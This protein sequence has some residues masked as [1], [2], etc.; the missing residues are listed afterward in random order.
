MKFK[1]LLLALLVVVTLCIPIVSAYSLVGNSELA[2]NNGVSFN[3]TPATLIGSGWVNINFTSDSLNQNMNLLV[4]VNDSDMIVDGMQYYN[5]HSEIR[6]YICEGIDIWYNR[7]DSHF[8]CWENLTESNNTISVLPLYNHEYSDNNSEY[9]AFYWYEI[10]N[11]SDLVMNDNPLNEEF[12]NKNMWYYIESFPVEADAYYDIRVH[13]NIPKTRLGEVPRL[14]EYD[15]GLNPSNSHSA[16]NPYYIDPWAKGTTGL[17]AYYKMEETTGTNV[18]DSYGKYNLTSSATI[19]SQAGIINTGAN[20]SSSLTRFY[21]TT[22]NDFDTPN[23]SISTWVYPKNTW[24][25]N[26]YATDNPIYDN[27]YN[28]K[29]WWDG[30]HKQ[31]RCQVNTGSLIYAYSTSS[32][33][34][35]TWHQIV[36]TGGLN[37]PL[38]LWIDGVEQTDS[39]TAG[40]NYAGGAYDPHVGGDVGEGTMYYGVMDEFGYWNN[41]ILNITDIAYLYNSGAPSTYQQP[42][43]DTPPVFTQNLVA[44]TINHNTTLSYDVNCTSSNTLIYYVNNSMVNI[45]SGTGVITD[46]PV[47]GDTGSY[48]ISVIC[49]DGTYNTTQSFNYT[50]TDNA[51]STGT[52]VVN[53]NTPTM[54]TS[55]IS[56]DDTSTSDPD[57]DIV[58][59]TYKWFKD[60]ANTGVTTKTISNASFTLYSNFT[61]EIKPTDTVLTGT[62]HNSTPVEI[63]VGWYY[64]HNENGDNTTYEFAT[65]S[66]ILNVSN[67]VGQTLSSYSFQFIYDGSI[68]NI[69]PS[70]SGST[71]IAT[72]NKFFDIENAT[73]VANGTHSYHWIMNGITNNG[74][75]INI[76]STPHNIIVLPLFNISVFSENTTDWMETDSPLISFTLTRFNSLSGS[77]I[78]PNVLINYSGTDYALPYNTTSTN[79]NCGNPQTTCNYLIYDNQFSTNLI[80][81]DT[82]NKTLIP[83]YT[84]I[85]NG[86]SYIR[87]ADGY[88]W[89]NAVPQTSI[90]LNGTAYKMILTN[91]SNLSY[92]NITVMNFTFKDEDTLNLV[93]ASSTNNFHSYITNSN[94]SRQISI[95]ETNVSSYIIC[96]KYGLNFQNDFNTAYSVTNFTPRTYQITNE[97][98]DNSSIDYYT[99]LMLNLSSAQNIIVHVL[100]EI[101]AGY[102]STLTNPVSVEAYMYV[103]LT[104]DY[105]LVES[106]Y[107]DIA[108][109]VQFFLSV[110]K[111]HEY[112]FRVKF[113]STYVYPKIISDSSRFVMSYPYEYW[114]RLPRYGLNYLDTSTLL[115]ILQSQTSITY[116]NNTNLITGTWTNM[117][118]TLTNLCFA[119]YN[120]TNWNISDSYTTQNIVTANRIYRNCTTSTSGLVNYNLGNIT[121]EYTAVFV[122][123]LSSDNN[124][125]IINALN[126]ENYPSNTLGGLGFFL[127]FLLVGTM[128]FA[129]LELGSTATIVLCVGSL[130][131]TLFMPIAMMSKFALVGLSLV[132]LIIGLLINR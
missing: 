88:A 70:I 57:G 22:T 76:S 124:D 29:L 48:N 18:V 119:V 95:S 120:T 49:G 112:M 62:A 75:N 21:K 28:A 30:S 34:K 93:N 74:S 25:Y 52:P 2:T 110:D 1:F 67:D 26:S 91:C 11:Y 24:T 129:G 63:G 44:Q 53:P 127:A 102:V 86:I 111:N 82:E 12:D 27:T 43:F 20:F 113:G 35:N 116:N 131:I 42:P 106:H 23:W 9:N 101:D 58:S 50:I 64:S 126:I 39:N 78:Q 71:Y 66:Y 117:N 41:T 47:V 13:I 103:P 130:M 61:C 69:T 10:I 132:G 15:F 80:T 89:T 36:C 32:L 94:L 125:Y 65:K 99:L 54:T 97:L 68:I 16:F 79:S 31:L 122:G 4:G 123:T 14:Y 107:T 46:T 72:M 77:T 33:T 60:G 45:N 3:V 96:K 56:C 98:A 114:I 6:G 128:V 92:A 38:K 19:L 100:D 59:F 83:R 121:G 105:S 81:N 17:L 5:P 73:S 37:L 90:A 118:G 104:N 51:P 85:Y 8:W 55:A 40:S 84:F 108:G 7:T 115:N 87:G 109:K